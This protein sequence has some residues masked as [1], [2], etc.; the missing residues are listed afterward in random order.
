MAD[1]KHLADTGKVMGVSR[2]MSRNRAVA[3]RRK[4]DA[5][6]TTHAVAIALRLGLIT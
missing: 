6:T 4:L 5:E 2:N 1:G 3:I